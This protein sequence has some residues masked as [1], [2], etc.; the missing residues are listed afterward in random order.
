MRQDKLLSKYCKLCGRELEGTEK[1]T[2]VCINCKAIGNRRGAQDVQE[3]F[4]LALALYFPERN[5]ATAPGPGW[6]AFFITLFL[7]FVIGVFYF[8]TRDLAFSFKYVVVLAFP[9]ELLT[10]V[11]AL[12]SI[13]RLKTNPTLAIV[14]L[15][16]NGS[17]IYWVLENARAIWL[18]LEPSKLAPISRLSETIKLLI[19]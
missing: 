15:V 5:R 4:E 13:F 14:A 7:V 9:L 16:A 2:G 17:A 18:E 12:F 19:H 6:I 10:A 3:A 11:L 1:T 8:I